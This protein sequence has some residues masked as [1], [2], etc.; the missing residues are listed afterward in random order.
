M[1]SNRL[2]FAINTGRRRFL[3]TVG[4]ASFVA[5]SVWIKSARA[6]AGQVVVR[7]PGGAV[8]ETQR[9]H[10]WA[11]FEQE[12]GIRVVPVPA[13]AAKLFAMF[14]SGNVEIDVIDIDAGALL[15]LESKGLLAPIAFEKWNRVDPGD[16]P[17]QYRGKYHVG[18]MIFSTVIGINT[19]AVPEGKR[20]RNW[21]EFW[22]VG[23]FSGSRSLQGLATGYP[24]FESALMAD[25]VPKDKVY[26]MDLDRAFASLSRIRPSIPKFWDSGALSIQMLIDRETVLSSVWSSR[27]SPAITAG[28]PLVIE[29][30]GNLMQVQCYGV[31]KNAKN[32]ENAQ[33]FVEFASRPEIQAAVAPPTVCGVTNRKAEPLLAPGYLD[34]AAGGPKSLDKGIT[35]NDVWW[36]ENRET[37][38]RR[39]ADWIR[40]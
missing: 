13:T 17:D 33:A 31:C 32:E 27:I 40:G 7:S 14:K 2:R 12:T 29:W 38:N 23:R 9:A 6:A 5:P 30:D 36:L 35:Y 25:G 22:D 28:K 8:E 20:P 37:V 19:A 34:E 16:I 24:N 21:T 39:W 1:M 11:P 10:L 15:N 3:K 18:Y 4:A 26:P